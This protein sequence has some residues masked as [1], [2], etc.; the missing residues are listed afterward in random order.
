MPQNFPP[1]NSTF[2][3][4]IAEGQIKREFPCLPFAQTPE[5][6]HF[7]G[8][9]LKPIQFI[10]LQYSRCPSTQSPCESK[11]GSYARISPLSSAISLA[12]RSPCLRG[13]TLV[14]SGLLQLFFFLQCSALSRNINII[15]NSL[16][17][18]IHD[19]VTFKYVV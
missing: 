1:L 18:K 7:L 11:T 16:R 14:L 17:Y 12:L 6:N 19:Y 8:E 15:G 5:K 2:E 10:S 13:V 3:I 4:H 9:I